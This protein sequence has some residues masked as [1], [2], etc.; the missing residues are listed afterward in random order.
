LGERQTEDLKVTGSIRVRG[1]SSFVATRV[2]IFIQPPLLNY[3]VRVKGAVYLHITSK[4]STLSS[5]HPQSVLI[6][7]AHDMN[8]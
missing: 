5:V 3:L 1:N 7:I 4:Y 6:S 2:A 8:R